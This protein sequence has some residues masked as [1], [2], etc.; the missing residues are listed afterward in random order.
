ML[1]VLVVGAGPSGSRAA[2]NFAKEGYKVV[3]IDRAEVIGEPC[4]CA[5]LITPRTFDYLGYERPILKEMDG[6][7]LWGPKDSFLDFQA[8]ETKALVI[9]RPDLDRSI[10][11][12][13]SEA[14][15]ELLNG[16]T[17]LGH[18]KIKGGI[19]AK[20]RNKDK[21]FHIETKL[22]VG[23]DGP[24]SRVAKN[25]GISAKREILTAFG[26][27]VKGYKGKDTHVDLFVGS[28]LAPRFFGWGIP[29]GPNEGRIGVATTLPHKPMPFFR[30]YF[31]KGAPSKLLGGAKIINLISGLIPFGIAN[32]SYTDN[33]ILTGDAA[34]MAKPT[35]GGG[36][37]SGLISADAAFEVASRALDLG[38]L[39]ADNLSEYQELISNRIGGELRKGSYLRKAFLSLNDNQ[40]AEIIS[41]LGEAKVKKAIERTGDLDYASLAAFSVLKTQPKLIKFAPHL[42]KPFI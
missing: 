10:A 14:G 1:D 35:S 21:K 8:S 27:D 32:P 2:W 42:L 34:G 19:K 20:I 7:R 28:E 22:L 13:A 15:A 39:C 30:D 41:I 12:K 9:D 17:Y 37:Y 23:A 11:D 29:T 18:E 25:S 36:I 3:L 33:V 24:L 16:H 31:L 26:A 4:Q 6:A 38:D 40:L 5:G